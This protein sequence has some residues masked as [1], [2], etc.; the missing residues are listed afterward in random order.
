M[1]SCSHSFNRSS[2]RHVSDSPTSIPR[3]C[4]SNRLLA[5]EAFSHAHK[6]VFLCWRI[7]PIFRRILS[8]S[9]SHDSHFLPFFLSSADRWNSRPRLSFSP[10]IKRYDFCRNFSVSDGGLVCDRRSFISMLSPRRLDRARDRV[11]FP[12][13]VGVDEDRV[14]LNKRLVCRG[15]A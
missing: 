11:R 14:H 12:K 6:N 13:S 7:D 8:G 2:S 15:S 4:E 9:S 10:L 5:S 1:C 3:C